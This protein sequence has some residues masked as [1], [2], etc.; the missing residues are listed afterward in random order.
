MT[1]STREKIGGATM[2][3][4]G[5]EKIREVLKGLIRYQKI[6]CHCECKDGL[7]MV[8]L[9][10]ALTEIEEIVGQGVKE[11]LLPF[12]EEFLPFPFRIF[13]EQME[14]NKCNTATITLDGIKEIEDGLKEI[15]RKA[16]EK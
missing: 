11:Q 3:T 2:N 9:D 10:K 15:I 8:S 4:E 6:P 16:G 1:K 13:R 14:K 5:R 12:L 7:E